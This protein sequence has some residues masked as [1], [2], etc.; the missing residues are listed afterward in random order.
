[1]VQHTFAACGRH[2]NSYR[3]QKMRARASWGF[4][5][6]GARQKITSIL[7]RKGSLPL[8]GCRNRREARGTPRTGEA[9][10]GGNSPSAEPS[11][12]PAPTSPL[13][14][15]LAVEAG[16]VEPLSWSRRSAVRQALQGLCGSI[17]LQALDDAVELSYTVNGE[18]I[19]EQIAFT[20]VSGGFGKR[21]LFCCPSGGRDC[22][23]LPADRAHSPTI[24]G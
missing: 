11:A 18:P 7:R 10:P 13:V 4:K 5:R 2:V 20:T 21:Q 15:A 19:Q 3:P 12:A 9:R 6:R 14:D 24:A 8:V 17:S 23:M 16:H 1:M 22:A